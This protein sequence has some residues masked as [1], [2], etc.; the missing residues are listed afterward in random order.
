M[1]KYCNDVAP[2]LIVHSY[3]GLERRV[4]FRV[5]SVLSCSVDGDPH[6][7][8]INK[9]PNGYKGCKLKLA[10]AVFEVFK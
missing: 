2:A 8:T 9:N 1:G 5:R 4:A 7:E 10:I 3:E 6:G